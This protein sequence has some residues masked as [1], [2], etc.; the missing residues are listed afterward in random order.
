MSQ[1]QERGSTHV[2]KVNRISKEEMDSMVERCVYE[3]PPFCSAACPLKLDT[4]AMLKAAAEG[5]FK[6]ALLLYEKIAPFPLILSQGCEAPCE[7]ACRLCEVGDGVAVRA[8]E[9]AVARFGERS[10]LGGVFRTKKRKTTAIFGS[11]LFA[12]FLAG[13]LEKKAY[14][15][16]V[17]CEEPDLES[18]LHC[19]TAFLDEEAFELEAR[20]LQGKDIQFV[21]GCELSPDF[22]AEQ[23]AAFDVVCASEAVAKRVY[24]DA[25]CIPELMF[26]EER[27]LVMGFGEGVMAAAFG[28]KKAALT[29]DRLAQKLDPR[30]TRGS[31]GAV[32]SRLYTDLSEAETLSRVPLPA[33]GYTREQAAEEAK[34]CIQCHCEECLK[35]CAYLKHYKKHPGLLAKEI[36]NNTQ[37]IMG[38]HQLNKPM[39]ACSLCGQC[40]VVC[41]NGFD[42]ARVCSG[43]RRNMV[44]TDKMPLAPH[45]FALLDMLFSNEEAFL[46]RPQ[47]GYERCK[48]VFFPGC[49]AAA[50]APATVRAAYEDLCARLDG[51]VALMLGC[52]GAICDWAGRYEMYDKTKDFIDRELAKLGDPIVIAGCPTCKKELSEHESVQLTGIWD[53]LLE[54]GLPEG[55]KKL[56]R[57]VALHDSCGARGDEQVQGAVRTLCGELGCELVDTPYSG[58]RS[59]CCGYGGLTAYANREVAQEMTEK[60]LERS[61]EAYVSYCMACRDRFARQGRESH[62]VLELVYGTDAGAPPDISE[63]RYSRLTLKNDLLREIWQEETAEMKLD[64][65]LTYTDEARR[66]MDERMILT[67]DVIAVLDGFR[68]TGEAILDSDTGLLIARR[69]VGNATFWV[70]FTRGGD[71]G[72][73][74]HRAYSH[75]MQVVKREG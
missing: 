8:I 49:Q 51:G 42:M 60:C 35:S 19:E 45:E 9:A 5:D 67:A 18:F 1:I 17:F 11:G 61:G 50:I 63:K 27:Q 14:P 36:Y 55:A 33:A 65:E 54:L 7:K 71:D 20:R 68:E 70:A 24:L 12:L 38:D 62:H 37:I 26:C 56:E 3:Q 69:R 75:R 59:P 15:V 72:Y 29:V 13:E 21:F 74:V 30:N 2:Y 28:A 23:R 73:V 41:P 22:F 39:N 48:Y 43:A 25:V 32:E 44:S 57:P 34:R 4:R 46:C 6:K 64:Y 31:E 40:T 53:V 10:K 47:P 66:M 16:T 58:D 52:C